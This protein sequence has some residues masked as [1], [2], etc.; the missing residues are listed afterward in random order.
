[1]PGRK[2]IKGGGYGG[3]GKTGILYPDIADPLPAG[4][5]FMLMYY[6]RRS[7]LDRVVDILVS[8]YMESR[9]G[10]VKIP[11]FDLPGIVLKPRNQEV[12]G[13]LQILSGTSRPLGGIGGKKIG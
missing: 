8:V 3:H 6:R 10:K 9:Q 1:V 4:S 13:K 5:K 7:P 11:R 2:I 12:L